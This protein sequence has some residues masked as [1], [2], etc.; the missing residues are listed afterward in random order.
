MT[1]EKWHFWQQDSLEPND[2]TDAVC[3]RPGQLGCADVWRGSRDGIDGSRAAA[4]LWLADDD[5]L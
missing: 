5:Q 3:Q 4:G 2:K 1:N